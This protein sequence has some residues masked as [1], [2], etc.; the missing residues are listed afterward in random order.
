VALRSEPMPQTYAAVKFRLGERQARSLEHMSDKER[1]A[2]EG[3]YFCSVS[4][5]PF[6]FYYKIEEKQV[7]ILVVHAIR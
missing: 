5:F 7:V 1:L 6:E 2:I 3:I 4:K